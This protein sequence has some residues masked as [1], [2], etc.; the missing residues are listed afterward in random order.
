MHF[1]PTKKLR[2]QANREIVKLIAWESFWLKQ[3]DFLVFVKPVGMFIHWGT[4]QKCP[5]IVFPFRA[6]M[7][8]PYDLNSLYAM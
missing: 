5:T 2:A 8:L 3:F 6:T 7:N 4:S 1:L